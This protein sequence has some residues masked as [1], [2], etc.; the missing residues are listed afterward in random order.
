[1]RSLDK[2]IIIEYNSTKL[3]GIL[4]IPPKSKGIA[5]FAHGSG[6]DRFSQRNNFVARILQENDIATLLFDLLTKKE[7]EIYENRF[8]IN[9]LANRLIA[10][11]KWVMINPETR[12]L[13]IG[14]FGAS[15][16]AAAAI[17]ASIKIPNIACI[18]SR[19]GRVDL[20]K[21][22]LQKIKSPTLL[23]VGELDYQILELNKEAYEMIKCEK[24]LAIV[25][26]ASHLFE[27]P[28][29]LE[30]V[31]ELAYRWFKKYFS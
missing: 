16:G 17:Q 18:V 31:A 26:G 10:A 9:L 5:I 25:K 4:N 7:D 15:T 29:A 23:I 12:N 30:E 3:E 13:R 22:Y 28:K 21:K 2:N 6:S 24:N 19:G 27:E 8:D 14:Y 20:A 11:T 1:M